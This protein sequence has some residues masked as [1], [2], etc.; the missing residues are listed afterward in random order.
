MDTTTLLLQDINVPAE[1]QN[2]KTVSP[3][4]KNTKV[5]KRWYDGIKNGTACGTKG[6][7]VDKVVIQAAYDEKVL[8]KD[9]W[10]ETV[11]TGHKCSGCGATK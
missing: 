10:S 2:N 11:V 6:Y 5:V 4:R 8:V 7:H 9:A 3:A 1:P